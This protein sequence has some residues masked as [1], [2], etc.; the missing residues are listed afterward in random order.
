MSLIERED[1]DMSLVMQAELLGLNRTGLY[2]HPVGPSAEELCL[3]RRIDE[4]CTTHQFYGSR[5][6]TA[7]PRRELVITRKAVQPTCGKL[8][9][10]ASVPAPT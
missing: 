7:E 9:W 8:G 3:K 4:I 2:Y 10:R 1:P 6:I 5:K